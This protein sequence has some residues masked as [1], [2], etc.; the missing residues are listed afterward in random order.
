MQHPP[1]MSRAT[2][3]CIGSVVTAN[4]DDSTSNQTTSTMSDC[5]N[6]NR[7]DGLY[8]ELVGTPRNR[9][10]PVYSSVPLLDPA[11][12]ASAQRFRTRF[13]WLFNWCSVAKSSRASRCGT[14]LM[15]QKGCERSSMSRLYPLFLNSGYSEVAIRPP[16]FSTYEDS[17][18]RLRIFLRLCLSER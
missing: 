17:L 16:F 3:G 7:H 5:K 4:G 14:V 12:T 2:G 10:C 15:W 6:T 18:T 11:S 9:A 13:D 8:Y 1:L